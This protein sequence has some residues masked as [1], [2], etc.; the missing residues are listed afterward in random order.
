MRNAERGMG[1]RGTGSV[2]RLLL[3]IVFFPVFL[4]GTLALGIVCWSARRWF[5]LAGVCCFLLFAAGGARAADIHVDPAAGNDTTGDGIYYAGSNLAGKIGDID[6]N[7]FYSCNTDR[8]NVAAGPH[9]DATEDDPDF[10]APDTK[11]YTLTSV[12]PLIN[13]GPN[14]RCV[15]AY[16]YTASGGSGGGGPLV[17]GGLAR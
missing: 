9:D 4:Q 7:W 17:G 1:N 6:S 15:G 14:E 10:T 11:D 5:P 16:G 8:T 12:S 13:A 2:M 3:Q